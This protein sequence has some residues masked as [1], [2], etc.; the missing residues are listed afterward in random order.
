MTWR[1]KPRYRAWVG[2][3]RHH[4]ATEAAVSGRLVAILEGEAEKVLLRRALQVG[5]VGA[6]PGQRREPRLPP[7]IVAAARC[8]VV[9]AALE[10]RCRRVR[11]GTPTTSA[12]VPGSPGLPVHAC[13]ATPG[14][15]RPQ[16]TDLSDINSWRALAPCHVKIIRRVLPFKHRGDRGRPPHWRGGAKRRSLLLEIAVPQG[17]RVIHDPCQR[18]VTRRLPLQGVPS[19]YRRAWTLRPRR[20][21]RTSQISSGTR[22]RGLVP[23]RIQR[24]TEAWS[25]S[26]TSPSRAP[27]RL[28]CGRPGRRGTSVPRRDDRIEQD[29]RLSHRGSQCFSIRSVGVAVSSRTAGA[30]FT[31][32]VNKAWFHTPCALLHHDA[33]RSHAYAAAHLTPS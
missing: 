22:P 2:Q 3:E 8:V 28:T 30:A 12:G 15:R 16:E 26:R 1:C 11:S 19:R 29:V 9:V 13:V 20:A 31:P 14:S 4:I 23:S 25:Y 5:V 32:R 17:C 27:S 24:R 10:Q 18:S 6:D 33:C 21:P 7:G